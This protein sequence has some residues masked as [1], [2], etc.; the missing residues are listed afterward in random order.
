MSKRNPEGLSK[1]IH[2]YWSIVSLQI[3]S[4]LTYRCINLCKSDVFYYDWDW[5]VVHKRFVL[6]LPFCSCTCLSLIISPSGIFLLFIIEL[7]VSMDDENP[8]L[9]AVW[10]F[11][12]PLLDAVFV[13]SLLNIVSMAS[14][15]QLLT[16][17]K[18]FWV[19][20]DEIEIENYFQTIFIRSIAR[21]S[22]EYILTRCFKHTILW[23]ASLLNDNLKVAWIPALC[24]N[25]HAFFSNRLY[26][27]Q[28][29]A[30]AVMT[31]SIIHPSNAT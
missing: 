28:I 27:R 8:L 9:F 4:D 12:L 7:K 18:M 25:G 6:S 13:R 31:Q 21:E 19:C 11:M 26:H 3:K 22:I 23:I 1:Y 20:N 24:Y 14:R 5:F 10:E 16:S 17:D 15:R 30:N 29:N 2:C